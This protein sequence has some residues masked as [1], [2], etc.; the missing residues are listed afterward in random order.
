MIA[1]TMVN[2]WRSS[3]SRPAK[4]EHFLPKWGPKKPVEAR[5]MEMKFAAYAQAHNEQI[6]AIARRRAI[7]DRTNG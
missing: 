1:V 2:L 6:D 3:K 4:L 7:R 5:T